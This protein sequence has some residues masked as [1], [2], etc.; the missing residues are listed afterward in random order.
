MKSLN[1]SRRH[2]RRRAGFTL[3]E[4]ILVMAILVLLSSLAIVGVMQIQGSTQNDAAITQIGTLKQTCKMFKLNIGRYPTS[5][6]E[7]VTIPAGMTQQSW[8]GPYLDE[9]KLPADP[10]GNPFNYSAD[11]LADIVTITSNG[12]DG[13][14]G[15]ADDIGATPRQ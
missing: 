11:E 2:S 12:R 8:K 7:L 15:T 14:M 1:R 3:L 6:N 13:Q 10:W 9:G 4:L 5:L